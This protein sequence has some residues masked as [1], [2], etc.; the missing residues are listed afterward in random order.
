MDFPL[1]PLS[2]GLELADKVFFDALFARIQPRISEFSFANLFLFREVHDYSVSTVGDSTVVFG[3]GYDGGEYFLPPLG[4]DIGMALALLLEESRVLYGADESFVDG[5]LRDV[6]GVELMEDRDSFD[7][8]Y[9]REE[10]AE[11]P[12]NRYHKK[13]NRVNYF[14]SR[15]SFA[16]E[17]FSGEYLESSLHMLDDWR[18]I[19]SG[20]ESPSLLPETVA[21]GEALRMAEQLGLKG[22]VALVEGEVKAFVLGE[23]LNDTTAVCHFE[24]SDTFMEGLSQLMDR[25]F[26]RLCFTECKYMNREQDL[27][28]PNLRRAKLSYHPVEMIR[29]FR[30]R[31]A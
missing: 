24:K 3:R 12:G 22:L 25:E 29:K 30:V 13:K 14:T 28:E 31:R 4:G 18:R 6:E 19:R 2:R 23:K 17:P 11:L 15:H 26:A 9:L 10:L 1:Y 8:I 7:Y 16:I 27:G 20:V 21:A 5:F